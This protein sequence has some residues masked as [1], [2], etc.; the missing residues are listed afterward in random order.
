L[1][2]NENGVLV[3]DGIVARLGEQHF[4]VNTTSGGVERTCDAFEE[5]LQCEYADFKVLVTPVTARWANVTVA[6]PQAWALLEAAGLDAALSPARS[7]HMTLASARLDDIPLRVLRAS[8]SGEL[9]YE[10]NIPAES[11]RPLFDRLWSLAPRFNAST[12]GIEALQSMRIE[13]GYIH[14]GTDSDGTTQPGDIG[15]GRSIETK[16]A[17]FVGRRSLSRTGTAGPDRLQL[18]G[19]VAADRRTLLPVGAHLANSPPPTLTEGHVTSSTWSAELGH[20]IS[21]G[22]L[23]RGAARTGERIGV[24]HLG[25]TIASEV[26]ALPFVDSKGVRVNG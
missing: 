19:L 12:Y 17:N 18:V 20:P 11:A 13:K 10:I 4:W 26:V 6:G 25:T 22:M 8:F 5:W 7:K 21:L 14:I 16:A 3:D 9:G 23:K 1:L 2:L 24:H 15:F